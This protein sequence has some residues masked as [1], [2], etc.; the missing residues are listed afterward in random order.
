MF[1]ILLNEAPLREKDVKRGMR[2]RDVNDEGGVGTGLGFTYRIGVA[3]CPS[4]NACDNS[5]LLQ[6][7]LILTPE[8]EG[9]IH[10]PHGGFDIPK[11]RFSN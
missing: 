1:P 11:T 8:R 10:P 6:S 9:L 7:E 3:P 2:K 4:P 5:T